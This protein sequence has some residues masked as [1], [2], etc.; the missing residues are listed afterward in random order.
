[1]NYHCIIKKYLYWKYDK[2]CRVMTLY[3]FN[4]AFGIA[5]NIIKVWVGI[6]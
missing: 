1:M 4:A 3:K 2:T 5:V 6:T